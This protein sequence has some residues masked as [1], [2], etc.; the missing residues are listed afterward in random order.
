LASEAAKN[1]AELPDSTKLAMERT[2]AAYERTLLAWVRTAVSLISFGFSIYKFFQYMREQQQVE[3]VHRLLGPR[4]VAL[5]MIGMGV[6]SL[7]L[8]TVENWKSRKR[9]KEQYHE[10]PFSMALVIA[11]LISLLGVLAFIAVIYHQ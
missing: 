4:E 2:H 10:A 11:G 1:L 7:S 3:P 8:A 9:V 5:I 6:G